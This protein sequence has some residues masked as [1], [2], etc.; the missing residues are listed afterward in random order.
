[1]TKSREDYRKSKDE[2]FSTVKGWDKAVKEGVKTAIDPANIWEEAYRK[3]GEVA[4][5]FTGAMNESW[6]NSRASRDIQ[7]TS[8]L[9]SPTSKK[10]APAQSAFGDKDSFAFPKGAPF[11]HYPV[12][13]APRSIVGKGDNVELFGKPFTDQQD[14]LKEGIHLGG[15]HYRSWD[16][17]GQT[18]AADLSIAQATGQPVTGPDIRRDGFTYGSDEDKL[19]QIRLRLQ[20][21]N[22]GRPTIKHDG[23]SAVADFDHAIRDERKLLFQQAEDL[24]EARG[25]RREKARAL[26]RQVLQNEG[27]L[28][29]TRLAQE[30]AT[31]RT[32]LTGEQQM[33]VEALQQKGLND[34]K[35]A[36]LV[37]KNDIAFANAVGDTYESLLDSASPLGTESLS[38][39]QKDL[40]YE[41]AVSRVTRNWNIAKRARDGLHNMPVEPDVPPE[42]E[43]NPGQENAGPTNAQLRD[44]L[45]QTSNPYYAYFQQFMNMIGK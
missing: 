19:N 22:R 41:E 23:V 44:R 7:L 33:A 45:L 31:E 35:A 14:I 34:R 1:M 4:D 11:T 38:Q 25:D 8:T 18:M 16:S 15:R 9:R 28:D 29:S 43:L 37:Q 10:D 17:L 30:A 24:F 12:A 32:R 26:A 13:Q 5:L 20:E 40:L 3:T 42:E 6:R 27:Y 36:E 2:L 39:E 21:L